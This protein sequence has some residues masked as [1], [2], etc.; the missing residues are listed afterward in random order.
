M[1]LIG[2][3]GDIRQRVETIQVSMAGSSEGHF[4]ASELDHLR[5]VIRLTVEFHYYL[6]LACTHRFCMM[7]AS[8]SIFSGVDSYCSITRAYKMFVGARESRVE[9]STIAV[10]SLKRQFASVFDEFDRETNFEDKCRL[11]L[12]LFKLQIVFAGVSYD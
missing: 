9:W 10:M 1:Q 8:E 3:S 6:Q 2:T 4:S 11:L 7:Y 5:T 12:D